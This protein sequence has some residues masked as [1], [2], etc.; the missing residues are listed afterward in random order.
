MEDLIAPAADDTDVIK[1][2]TTES[3]E[4]DVIQASNEVPV[5]VDFWAPWCGP[6]KT[7]GP[8]IEKV[9]REARGKVR[10]VKVN[11]D[12]NQQIAQALRIQSIPAV[13]G[14]VKGQP[15]DGF[16]GAQPESQIKAF[17]DRL[18]GQSGPS[19]VDEAVEQAKAALAADDHNGAAALFGQVLQQEPDNVAAIAGMARC[20]LALGDP[21]A[22]AEVLARAGDEHD[23]DP[24]ISGARAAL[25]LAEQAAAASGEVG[26]LEA[27]IAANPNDFNARLE[28]AK[29][30][31]GAGDRETAVD[32]LLEILGCDL[33][34]NDDA[35]RIQLLELFEAMGPTDPLTLSARRRLSSLL[36]S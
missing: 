28:L 8:T 12:E 23:D 25:A 34:W 33:N 36:F 10:L 7:L 13:F 15:V 19:P 17:V 16:V 18:A 35:A 21:G 3:F 2:S 9:V 31:F 29:A 26:G 20:L 11:I 6:C 24:D 32:H 27:R 14:F 1:D 4:A 30:L 22:A 5:V